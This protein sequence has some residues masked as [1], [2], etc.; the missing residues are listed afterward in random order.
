MSTK[1]QSV[2]HCCHYVFTQGKRSMASDIPQPLW[3]SQLFIVACEHWTQNTVKQCC[4]SRQWPPYQALL[5]FAG[6]RYKCCVIFMQLAP[7][8]FLG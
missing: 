3:Y 1:Q 8:R 5:W 2:P 4:S 6:N 7:A